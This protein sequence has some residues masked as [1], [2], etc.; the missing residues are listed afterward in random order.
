[1]LIAVCFD[2]FSP[3]HVARLAAAARRMNVVG[4]EVSATTPDY[5]WDPVESG[6]AFRRI[7]LVP[8]GN[9]LVIPASELRRRIWRVLDD[10][11][12]GVVAVHG[13][14]GRSAVLVLAWAVAR[15]VPVVMMS[16]STAKDFRR[17]AAKEWIKGRLVRLAHTGLVGGAM[18]A[19]YIMEL[20]MSETC[21]FKG[22]DVVDNAYFTRMAGLR[23]SAERPGRLPS[24]NY[25]LASSR[26]LR[27]KNLRRLL[28]AFAA[29]SR[30]AGP[31]GWE[32][33]L[34]GDGELRPELEEQRIRLRLQSIVHMPGF[35]QYGEL[36]DYYA[37]A[38]AFVH[39]STKDTWGLVVN[40]AMASGLP[41]LVS[42]RCGCAPDLVENGYNG[43]T[44][45]PYDVDT[46]A[47]LMLKI[48]SDDFDRPAMG[49]ASQR[50]I[51][52]WTPDT[53]AES[54]AQAADV[55][56]TSPPR[57]ADWTDKALLRALSC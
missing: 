22:Y 55:A 29:Y 6:E 15:Q 13:W 37:W 44:F 23:R 1:M 34:L 31:R 40:E 11:G 2:S 27:M 18:H 35:I 17:F 24:H 16:D 21:V 45:D 28:E 4:I 56:L 43:F 20:G 9:A 51:S 47:N 12:P 41:V 10:L 7:V 46:L 30:V 32:L 38:G 14:S 8:E 39:A 5:A 49:L 48:S 3:Y 57:H 50:I 54:L 26:F 25:F 19:A 42:E 52:R 36:P 33:V 53:F